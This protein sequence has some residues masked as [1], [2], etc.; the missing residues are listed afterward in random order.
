MSGLVV[1][2]VLIHKAIA[3]SIIAGGDPKIG[4]FGSLSIAVIPA[5]TGEWPGMIFAVTAATAV[6]MITFV[7]DHELQCRFAAT[8]L[9]GLL[10]IVAGYLELSFVMR[11]VSKSVMI[12]FVDALAIPIFMAQL[13]SPSGTSAR[14]SRTL[15]YGKF[16][17]SLPGFKP[18]PAIWR[19]SATPCC[20]TTSAMSTSSASAGPASSSKG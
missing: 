12:G 15:W 2:L 9:A 7:R 19:T 17:T 4:L 3:F 14:S 6:L 13:T 16:A 10:Q 11:F 5:I 1:A 18:P 8:V 20:R